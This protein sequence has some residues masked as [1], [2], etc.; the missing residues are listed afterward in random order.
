MQ[1][2]L[3]KRKGFTLIRAFGCDLDLGN[4]GGHAFAGTQPVPR[5]RHVLSNAS[6]T[7]KI[8]ALP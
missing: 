2:Q 3:G 6:V 5:K 8:S 4:S 7:S 1:V